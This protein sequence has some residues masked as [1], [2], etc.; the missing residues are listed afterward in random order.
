MNVLQNNLRIFEVVLGLAALSAVRL[1]LVPALQ[2]LLA[3]LM[4]VSLLQTAISA[5]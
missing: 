4:Q 2:Q 5:L 3:R 1:S